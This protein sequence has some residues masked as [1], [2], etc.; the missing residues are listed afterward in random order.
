V[1]QEEA[2]GAVRAVTVALD[3]APADGAPAPSI[4]DLQLLVTWPDALGDG[5]D[6]GVAAG[7]VALTRVAT[8]PAIQEAHKE[9]YVDPTTGK[10]YREL[11]TGDDPASGRRFAFLVL[12]TEGDEP[13]PAGRWL[14][15]T[16]RLGPAFGAAKAPPGPYTFALVEREQ[17]FAPPTADQTLWGQPLGSPVVVWTDAL[18]GP[19]VR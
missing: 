2:D 13:I 19:H 6:G 5:A 9:L 14:I 16:F 15:L 8:G 11:E 12:S 10:P 3:Y 7:D 4:A 17:T 18:G 1:G